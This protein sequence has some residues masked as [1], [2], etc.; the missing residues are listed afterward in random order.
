VATLRASRDLGERVRGQPRAMGERVVVSV[1]DALIGVDPTGEP[2]WRADTARRASLVAGGR[3]VA[4]VT[5]GV[6][7]HLLDTDTG[8]ELARV[9]PSGW[10]TAS[11]LDDQGLAVAVHTPT[12]GRLYVHDLVLSEAADAR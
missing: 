5:G 10:F 9:T 8:V 12:R 11:A 3:T 1:G 4:A 2:A 7:L 6:T